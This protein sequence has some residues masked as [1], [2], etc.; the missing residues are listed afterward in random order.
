[1]LVVEK[2]NEDGFLLSFSKVVNL[3]P[4]CLRKSNTLIFVRNYATALFDFL[5]RPKAI[6][7][8]AVTINCT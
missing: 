2:H 1:M 8:I 6:S 7:E 4:L 5:E 3:D